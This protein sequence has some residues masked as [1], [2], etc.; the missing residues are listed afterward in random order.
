MR[1]FNILLTLAALASTALA[2]A[3]PTHT[4]KRSLGITIDG[5]P[6]GASTAET[7]SV[8]RAT[9]NVETKRD[10][11]AQ[12]LARG[13]GPLPPRHRSRRAAMARR[14]AGVPV[15]TSGTIQVSLAST[16]S[17]LGF[18]SQASG[19]N[20]FG[21]SADS[22]QALDF[23]FSVDS[24]VTSSAGINIVASSTYAATWPYIGG[25]VGAANSNAD[26]SSGSFNYAFIQGTSLTPDDSPPA[27]V[28]NSYPAVK[29]SESAIWNY[30]ATTGAITAQ[31]VN[32]DGSTPATSIMYVSGSN[33]LVA[34]G[35]ATV[36]A[37]AFSGS[38]AVTFTLV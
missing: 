12:R 26:L 11:N 15:A 29:Q 30:D 35:D 6:E 9:V 24:T 33:A 7:R 21:V 18:I 8:E 19:F 13:L 14:S 3:S 34:T 20:H 2:V 17:V 27:A 37:A 23:Q 28:S 25:I 5:E 38:E 36:F 10:T 1:S 4:S 22:T 31:W 32:I 16:G